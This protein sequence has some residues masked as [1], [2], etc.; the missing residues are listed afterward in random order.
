[1]TTPLDNAEKAYELACLYHDRGDLKSM[2]RWM[3]IYEELCR[4]ARTELQKAEAQPVRLVPG[5]LSVRVG[6]SALDQRGGRAQRMT[7]E[8]S[9]WGSAVY[10]RTRK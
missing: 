6:D 5:R 8:A 1:M 4:D 7:N 10:F 9:T 2:I 3:T